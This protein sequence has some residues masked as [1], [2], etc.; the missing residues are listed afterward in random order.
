MPV[1]I[2]SADD[3]AR[4]LTQ[5]PL[6]RKAFASEALDALQ[7]EA[8]Q[9]DC[10]HCQGERTFVHSAE[11]D[12]GRWRWGPSPHHAPWDEVKTSLPRLRFWGYECVKCWNAGRGF[13]LAQEAGPNESYL[14]TK[15]GQVPPWSISVNRRLEHALGGSVEHYKRGLISLSQS[16]GLGACAYFRRVVEDQMN[17]LLGELRK[18]LEAQDAEAEDIAQIDKALRSTQ[19]VDK[20][21]IAGEVCPA[22]LRPGDR[23]PFLLLHDHLSTGVHTLDEE[24]GLE[25][26]QEMRFCLDFVFSR[27]GQERAASQRFMSALDKINAD[28]ATRKAKEK[29]G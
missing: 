3:M 1:E 12:P 7:P 6:Y 10:A 18:L 20:A 23:N 25:A 29:G 13:L 27:M 2:Q 5:E 19:A 4:F 28:R 8:L 14:I 15:V 26:A 22:T 9:A 11:S 24:A 21:R 17:Q 16:Y